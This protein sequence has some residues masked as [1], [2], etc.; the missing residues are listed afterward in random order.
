M[1]NNSSQSV[2]RHLTDR[3]SSSVFPKPVDEREIR[4]TINLLPMDNIIGGHKFIN[5]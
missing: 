5:R 4:S 3:V 1:E 2:T